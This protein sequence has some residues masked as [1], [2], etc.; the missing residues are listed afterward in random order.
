MNISTIDHAM[1]GIGLQDFGA[2]P[3][4]GGGKVD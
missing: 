4:A 3:G 2:K 1:P